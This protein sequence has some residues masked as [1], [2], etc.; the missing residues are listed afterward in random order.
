MP[1]N[2]ETVTVDDI[3]VRLSFRNGF[4]LTIDID[5]PDAWH[6]VAVGVTDRLEIRYGT[7][8]EDDI[9]A[10]VASAAAGSDVLP[11]RKYAAGNHAF[12]E[13]LVEVD[14]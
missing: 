6:Y 10:S 8:S 9:T 12:I 7:A 14:L 4:Q 3:D 11:P 1:S 2:T 5:A 13:T